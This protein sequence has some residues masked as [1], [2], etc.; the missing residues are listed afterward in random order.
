MQFTSKLREAS[1]RFLLASILM[2]Q[3]TI[4]PDHGIFK[5]A[6]SGPVCRFHPTCSEYAAQSIRTFGFRGV[7]MGLKRVVSCNPFTKTI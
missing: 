6:Y 7:L 3:R 5:Y 1:I 2:Y 4:S